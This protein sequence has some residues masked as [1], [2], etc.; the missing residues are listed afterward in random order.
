MSSTTQASLQTA[1]PGVR[2]ILTGL[3]MGIFLASLDQTIVTTAGPSIAADLGA[4]HRQAWISSTYLL[5]S[6]VSAPLY[7][8]L[9]DIYGRKLLFMIAIVVFTIGSM[10]CAAAWNMP[11]L[12]AAR[13]L[14]GLGAGGLM[15]QALAITGQLVPPRERSRYQGMFAATTAS[16]ALLGPV[17]GG[18]FAEAPDL[19]GINGWR[20]MFLVNAPLAVIALVIVQRTLHLKHQRLP[21]RLD[22]TGAALLT[23]VITLVLVIV[24]PGVD[25]PPAAAWILVAFA[26]VAA[27]A[28]LRVERRMGEEAV[29]PLGLLR[30]RMPGTASVAS[31]LTGV[32]MY[33]N[34]LLIPQ[35]LQLVLG[36]SPT[37]SGLQMLATTFGVVT[38]SLVASHGIARFGRYRPF[39]IVGAA[40]LTTGLVTLVLVLGTGSAAAIILGLFLHGLGMGLSF[41]PLML[42]VQASVPST[43]LGVAT[44]FTP[45]FRQLSGAVGSAALVA[46]AFA[47]AEVHSASP[48]AEAVDP[49]TLAQGIVISLSISAVC[50]ALSFLV[51]LR[52]P[53]VNLDTSRS[54]GQTIFHRS[55]DSPVEI[56][57]T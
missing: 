49:P 39:P 40:L 22:F 1:R 11:A 31:V 36:L 23:C 9:S 15:T 29:L 35:Y 2:R 14:Q 44:T 52:L 46:L 19:L 12:A 57:C 56:T 42:A 38:G 28:F 32:C 3:L 50:A 53:P 24:D 5:T 6:T 21:H 30:L 8:K 45:F 47:I 7:G 54:M 16:A 4:S 34:V 33:S 20:W 25:V 48:G 37:H 17:V 27:G 41:Q 55:D 26:L 13:A 43:H 10:L 18:Y 51:L